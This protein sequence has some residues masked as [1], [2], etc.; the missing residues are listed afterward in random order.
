[1]EMKIETTMSYLSPLRV[2][3]TQRYETDPLNFRLI[4][5]KKGTEQLKCEH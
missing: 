1:M 3:I 2:T 4:N 5:K